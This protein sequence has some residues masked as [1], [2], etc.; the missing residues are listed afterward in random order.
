MTHRDQPLARNLPH[1]YPITLFPGPPPP[2][3]SSV[4]EMAEKLPGF[5]LQVTVTIKPSDV[6]AF[7]SHFTPVFEKVVAEPECVFFEVYQS[8]EQPGVLR[9]V[10]NWS[11][12]VGWVME[13]SPFIHL[14]ATTYIHGVLLGLRRLLGVVRKEAWTGQGGFGGE[15]MRFEIADADDEASRTRSRRSTTRLISR[16]RNRCS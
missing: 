13:V 10:E 2:I 11:K 12:P 8:P 5:S 9:W 16:R 15:G 3:P 1:P 7:L 6:P 4:I 14:A